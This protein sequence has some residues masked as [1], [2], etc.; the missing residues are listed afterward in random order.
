MAWQGSL[1]ERPS[2]PV[3]IEAAAYRG[4]PVYFQ[5]VGPWTRPGRTK[6]FEPTLGTAKPIL[7]RSRK[8]GIDYRLRK[9]ELFASKLVPFLSL[10][11]GNVLLDQHASFQLRSILDGYALCIDVAHDGS[12][13]LQL[14]ALDTVQVSVHS[15]LNQDPA[16]L[17]VGADVSIRPN[18]KVA[19]E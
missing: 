17:Q 18:S 10:G 1:P 2:V 13:L 12:R 7:Q 4:K 8:R 14:N 3:R 5:F 16:G 15:T 9:S 6:S 11:T 19:V